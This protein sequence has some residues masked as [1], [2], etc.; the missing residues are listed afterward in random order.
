MCEFIGIIKG[1]LGIVEEQQ[2]DKPIVEAANT[3][4]AALAQVI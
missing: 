3:E 2:V 4:I 1:S